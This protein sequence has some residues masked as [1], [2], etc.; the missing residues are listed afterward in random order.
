MAL[1]PDVLN[2]KTPTA[3]SRVSTG[4]YLNGSRNSAVVVRI[5]RDT[6]AVHFVTFQTGTLRLEVLPVFAFVREWPTKL[7]NY[8]IKRALRNMDSHAPYEA[9]AKKLVR[10]ILAA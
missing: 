10:Q 6:G 8:P 1:E 2:L 3:D 9:L 4:A 5:N 7:P